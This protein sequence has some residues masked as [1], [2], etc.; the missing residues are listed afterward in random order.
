MA[1]TTKRKTAKRSGE[2]ETRR[3]STPDGRLTFALTPASRGVYVER[4]E[5]V[6]SAKQMTHAMLVMAADEFVKYLET[7]DGRFEE[8][9]FYRLVQRHIEE[10]LDARP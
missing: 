7:D 3:L 9:A 4:A 1:M 10:M 6:D 2:S 5:T 8:P